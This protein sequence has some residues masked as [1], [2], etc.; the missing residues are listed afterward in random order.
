MGQYMKG[1]VVAIAGSALAS[2]IAVGATLAPTTF[3]AF[4]DTTVAAA[5]TAHAGTLQVDVVDNAGVVTETPRITIDNAS[6][7]MAMRKSTLNIKNNGSLTAS[8]RVTSKNLVP[9]G[10][11]LDDVLMVNVTDVSGAIV[12][13]GKLSTLD[14]SVDELPATVTATYTVKI[15]WPDTPADDNPYQGA[16]LTFDLTAD[17]S[18]IAGQ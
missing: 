5:N 16:S 10:Q 9:V 3:A 12:Y 15:T 17:A 11:N 7:N 18:S 6:P 4:S 14:F 8:M 13:T 1:T 2:A